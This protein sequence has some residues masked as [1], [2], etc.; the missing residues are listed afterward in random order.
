MILRAC[1]YRDLD[2]KHMDA[3]TDSVMEHTSQ[4]SKPAHLTIT[5]STQRNQKHKERIHREVLL[6]IRR[7][8]IG[9]NTEKRRK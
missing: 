6:Y 1:S 5:L 4:G 3:F 8:K 7:N 2:N 9:P